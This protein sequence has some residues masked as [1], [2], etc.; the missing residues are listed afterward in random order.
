MPLPNSGVRMRLA[1]ISK[2]SVTKPSVTTSRRPARRR[3]ADGEPAVEWSGAR[4]PAVRH[5]R[6]SLWRSIAFR[7]STGAKSSV[8]GLRLLFHVG[9]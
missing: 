2:P 1:T 5:D 4:M 8:S 3:R 6:F 9:W 7:Y